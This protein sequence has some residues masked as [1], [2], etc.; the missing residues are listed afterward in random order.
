MKFMQ[1]YF[2]GPLITENLTDG[3]RAV[4]EGGLETKVGLPIQISKEAKET[5]WVI[6]HPGWGNLPPPD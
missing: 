3:K 1:A 2:I 6:M 5:I 4:V